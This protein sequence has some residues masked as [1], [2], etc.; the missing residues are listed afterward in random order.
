M[1][2]ALAVIV[3]VIISATAIRLPVRAED[4]IAVQYQ[5]LLDNR[6]TTYEWYQKFVD[7]I[8]QLPEEHQP[9]TIYAFFDEDELQL[10]YRVVA[11]EIGGK[12]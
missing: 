10:F 12:Q 2:K 4:N 1:K 7:T 3:A 8:N 6:E 5:N 11:A 9:E